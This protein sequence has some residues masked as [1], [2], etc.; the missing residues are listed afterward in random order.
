[1]S[2]WD[3]VHWQRTRIRAALVPNHCDGKLLPVL[4]YYGNGEIGPP[5]IVGFD[6]RTVAERERD[7]YEAI[8]KS[9]ET[10]GR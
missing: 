10:D 1:M 3:T 2:R 6:L 9:G 4:T 7:L 8:M 5:T